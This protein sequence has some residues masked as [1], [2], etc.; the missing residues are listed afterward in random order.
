[1]GLEVDRA[2]LELLRAIRASPEAALADVAAALGLPRSNFGRRL[3]RRLV[4]PMNHLI[5]TG[6]VE[7]HGSRYR[8]SER[9]RRLLAEHALDGMV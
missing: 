9:G 7:C 6:L 1:V 4:G 3:N 2:E 5:E 8:L